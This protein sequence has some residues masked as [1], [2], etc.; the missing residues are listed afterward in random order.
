MLAI[1]DPIPR[2][3]K[4]MSWVNWRLSLKDTWFRIL[5]TF[6]YSLASRETIQY[7]FLLSIHNIVLC[8]VISCGFSWAWS[9]V[10]T[11]FTEWKIL[12]DCREPSFSLFLT[13]V[14]WY[15]FSVMTTRRWPSCALIVLSVCT[16]SSAATLVP[17]YRGRIWKFELDQHE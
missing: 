17:G 15:R 13:I 7:W 6:R 9:L 12:Y 11:S 1:Q 2:K 5:L 16:P 14:L 10:V 8:R 4:S 3:W